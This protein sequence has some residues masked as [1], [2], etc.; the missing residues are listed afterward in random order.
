MKPFGF[1]QRRRLGNRSWLLK[2]AGTCLAATAAGPTMMT[3]GIAVAAPALIFALGPSEAFSPQPVILAGP[4]TGLTAAGGNSEVTLA[5]KLPESASA[6]TFDYYVYEG[7]SSGGESAQPINDSPVTG[8]GYKATG[9][10]NGTAY[11]FE[12]AAAIG[13][14]VV[15]D[16]SAEVSAIPATTPGA[17]T[18]LTATAGSS[19]VTLSWAAPA[20][21][22]GSRVTSYNVCCNGRSRSSDNGAAQ[23]AG[24]PPAAAGTGIGR[25]GRAGC[26]P[27][28]LGERP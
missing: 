11:Y 3:G 19:Q 4:P 2:L 21:D 12:V 13:R 24:A 7:T 17:P 8:L 25:T 1:A 14:H 23:S 20:S 26:W 6:A 22:G 27:V 16:K 10:T 28:G 15:S 5:W 9:L 18:G